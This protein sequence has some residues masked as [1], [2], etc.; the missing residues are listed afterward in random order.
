MTA[1]GDI[2]TASLVFVGDSEDWRFRQRKM[3]GKGMGWRQDE[4]V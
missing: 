3:L 4:T 2:G 1:G